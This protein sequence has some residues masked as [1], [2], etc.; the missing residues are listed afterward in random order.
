ML[1]SNLLVCAYAST[2]IGIIWLIIIPLEI[3]FTVT[4]Y[5]HRFHPGISIR[6]PIVVITA[7]ICCMIHTLIPE[8][9]YFF[10]SGIGIK[11]FHHPFVLWIAYLIFPPFLLSVAV[12]L[13]FRFWL[14]HYEINY[15]VYK[16]KHN[17]QTLLCQ[18]MPKTD[19][20]SKHMETFGKWKNVKK[21]FII[22][23]IIGTIFE[24]GITICEH[25][26][27]FNISHGLSTIIYV[28]VLLPLI[29]FGLILFF[30]TPSFEDS[31]FVR[32]EL[33]YLYCL[34]GFTIT[35]YAIMIVLGAESGNIYNEI[36]TTALTMITFG[37][38]LIT[39]RISLSQVLKNDNNKY[40]QFGRL[41]L[42]HVISSTTHSNSSIISGNFVTQLMRSFSNNYD[43]HNN[44]INDITIASKKL[45]NVLISNDIGINC[46]FNHL[47]S[48]F[49]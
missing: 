6:Y 20:Y 39:E 17:W 16:S 33:R 7:S 40:T 31:F 25:P 35:L 45:F 28:L 41:Q 13:C 46:Y 29:I 3:Y 44:Q 2:M 15:A 18:S 11:F 26:K 5:Q 27:L 38:V 10:E 34:S 12:F 24:V 43:N 47:Q 8:Q 36:Q 32:K 49:A 37:C 9:F 21:Y 1:C 42:S 14:V 19:W 4:F 30:K 22:Y 23:F 48:E